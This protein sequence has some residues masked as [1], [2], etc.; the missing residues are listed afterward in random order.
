MRGGRV[1]GAEEVGRLA[2]GAPFLHWLLVAEGLTTPALE[3]RCGSRLR[4]VREVGVAGGRLVRRHAL[5]DGLGRAVEIAEVRVDGAPM[6]WAWL[7]APLGPW[8]ASRGWRLE[9]R[10]IR[11]LA[12]PN[13]GYWHRVFPEGRWWFEIL[14][15][16]Y[17]L[18][19]SRGEESVAMRVVEAW[20]P[21]L[22]R[23]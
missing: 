7:S 14:G 9:K 4:S 2:T 23:I 16:R 1:L 21:A 6:S 17:W 19:A 12:F 5:L 15:R 18:E 3:A 20:N 13:W 11:P 10:D 22:V 8:L